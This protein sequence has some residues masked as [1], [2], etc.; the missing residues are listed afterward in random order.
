MV[1]PSTWCCYCWWE[2]PDQP[3]S[4]QA[5]SAW[6]FGEG[7][8]RRGSP[9]ELQA[10]I[11]WM[12]SVVLQLVI[13]PALT[14]GLLYAGPWVRSDSYRMTQSSHV[15]T[16]GCPRQLPGRRIAEHRAWHW[17]GHFLFHKYSVSFSLE[18][19]KTKQKKKIS[20]ARQI[21]FS[22]FPKQLLRLTFSALRITRRLLFPLLNPLLRTT[23]RIWH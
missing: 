21:H 15:G 17:A 12:Y 18:M 5:W 13:Q 8:L 7:R 10:F 22:L 14:E 20:K 11:S 6:T 4:R 19:F 23:V 9:D 1:S 2:G 16:A 3:R